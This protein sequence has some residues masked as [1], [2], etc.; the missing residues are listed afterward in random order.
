MLFTF[1]ETLIFKVTNA[2]EKNDS[3]NYLPSLSR[4]YVRGVT[5]SV[6]IMRVALDGGSTVATT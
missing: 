5:H 4:Y 2:F 3:N 6:A 1:R